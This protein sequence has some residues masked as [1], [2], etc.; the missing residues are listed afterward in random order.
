MIAGE[1]LFNLANQFISLTV[2]NE[3]EHIALEDVDP[4]NWNT[5]YFRGKIKALLANNDL[6]IPN[7]IR[8]KQ[9]LHDITA[10]YEDSYKK[11][12]QELEADDS[13]IYSLKYIML[14]T[15]DHQWIKHIEMMTAF[16]RRDWLTFIPAGGSTAHLP[17]RRTRSLHVLI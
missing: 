1:N 16:K 13:F 17:K 12:L 5:S 8:T 15:L 3:I 10:P 4:E 2:K 7:T 9:D 6:A 14:G 11:Q